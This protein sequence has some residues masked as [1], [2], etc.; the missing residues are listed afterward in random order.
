MNRTSRLLLVSV[1]LSF[2]VPVVA[3][4]APLLG[5]SGG[6]GV[7][8]TDDARA[9]LT[10]PAAIG[11]RYPSELWLSWRG[12]DEPTRFEGG[13]GSTGPFG[14]AVTREAEGGYRYGFGFALG[15][16]PLRLGWA[17]DLWVAGRPREERAL[18]AR[19]GLLLRAAPWWSAGATVA[20][21]F[22]PSFAGARL[23][24]TYTVGLGLRPLAISRTR[25]HGAGV[26]FSLTGDVTMEERAAL[27]TARVRVGAAV[28]PLR[29]LEVAFSGSDH[30]AFTVGV[31]AR[32]ARS[33]FTVS[34]YEREDGTQ[35]G[36]WTFNSH[37]GDDRGF[38]VP[39]RERRVAVVSL[40][41]NLDDEPLVGGVTGGG[42]G[43]AARPVHAVLER[44][45]D[46]PFTKGVFLELNGVS[47]MAQL[48]ELRPRVQRLVLAGKPVVA[49]M[50]YGGGR[51]DLYLG[52]AATRVY[53]SPAASFDG[54]GLR[55]ERRSYRSMLERFG[56][57][58]DRASVGDFKSAYR[59]FSVDSTPPADTTVIQTML[60]QRQELFV[61]TVSGGRRIPAE[62]LTAVLD[63]RSYEART[64]ARLGVIDSV[65]WRDEALAELGRLTGLGRKPTT[66]DLA[67]TPESRER[68][69]TPKRIA[70]VYAGGAIVNGR[71]GNDVLS[72]A[73]M[74]D[75]TII[76]Q[77]ERAFRAPG[78]EA[79]V[80]R[81]DS[82]GGAA[83][84]SYLMDRAVERLKRETRKPLVVSMASVAASGGYFMSAHADRILANRHTVTGSIG[85]LY[86]KPSFE[87]VYEKL[88]VRQED[89][90]RGDYMRAFSPA[91]SW[92]PQDQAAADSAIQR[93]YR[94]FVSR[95]ADGRRMEW[96]E[97]QVYAQGRPWM[98]DDAVKHRLADSIGGLDAAVDEAR[99]L[100]GIPAGE[101]IEW[102][103]FRRP[104]G[105]LLDRVIG[106]W[107]RARVAETFDL[108]TLEPL[109]TV[110][111][112]WVTG[113]D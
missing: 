29:G 57:R 9:Y 43:R 53:A 47:G 16:G 50:E 73:T 71:S 19:A 54:L 65:G 18:D 56:M 55:V 106:S 3:A 5:I 28:E 88:G 109:Q 104:K 42:G 95:V 12:E 11:F 102:L 87:G 58:M 41:G 33:G 52:S 110:A 90:D 32:L 113:L 105:S 79:V 6:E 15:D 112:D 103:E 91:R 14:Y 13:L 75:R 70:V 40:G 68:W 38:A 66:V 69:S 94:T 44:A 60:R 49:Y 48:E 92:R 36:R 34:R 80:L 101:R 17:N 108:R 61:N 37:A 64:L 81:V 97:A 2:A 74:G 10:N 8:V 76:A 93:N 84:A 86:V 63:G 98:G 77:L 85:V 39:R 45:L 99:R 107:V 30:G 21:V 20:H 22:E 4:P 27:S 100:A 7:A 31:T 25:A 26:R 35:D 24:R 111:D 78:V 62:R 83:T 51:G 59:N 23:P 82:P 67:R 89:F 46:D 96:F 1:A 72:G